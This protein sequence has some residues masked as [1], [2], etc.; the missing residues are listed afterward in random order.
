MGTKA[1]RIRQLA[2]HG[3]FTDAE[4]HALIVKE[5][6]FCAESYI[7]VC[8]RQRVNGQSKHDRRYEQK[9]L[10]R[11]RDRDYQRRRYWALKEQGATA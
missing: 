1:D 6:G 10:R 3:I 4:I 5:F 8:A 9:P 7:R 11:A 2:K